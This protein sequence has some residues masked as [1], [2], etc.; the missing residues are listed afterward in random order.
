MGLVKVWNDLLSAYFVEVEEQAPDAGRIPLRQVVEIGSLGA[1]V[2]IGGG[3]ATTTTISD[4]SVTNLTG[5]I[6]AANT[7]RKGGYIQNLTDT[8]LFFNYGATCAVTDFTLLGYQSLPFH[9]DTVLYKGDISM[10]ASDAGPYAVKV[11]EV[12]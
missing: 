10:I 2:S 3:T 12:E 4:G 1:G 11:V 8:Q 5:V 9:V 6:I 7:D